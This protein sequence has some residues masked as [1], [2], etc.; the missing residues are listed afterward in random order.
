M[1]R[2][3]A[4]RARGQPEIFCWPR[5]ASLKSPAVASR[6]S[7]AGHAWPAEILLATR[8]QQEL[9]WWPRVA[10]RNCLLATRGQQRSGAGHA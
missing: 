3:H 9:W 8:G 5:V 7:G 6:N 2:S 10:S 4:L 1:L